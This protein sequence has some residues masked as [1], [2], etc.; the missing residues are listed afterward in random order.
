MKPELYLKTLSDQWPVVSTLWA[1][2]QSR[3]FSQGDLY[4]VARDVSGAQQ[5]AASTIVAKL[6]DCA[7][8]VENK[9]GGQGYSFASHLC[10]FIEYLLE[11]QKLGLLAEITAN[12]DTLRGHL[13]DVRAAL[14]EGRR[15]GFFQKCQEM[16]SRFHTLQRLVDQNTKA[17]YNLVDEAKQADRNLPIKDRYAKVIGAWDSYVRPALEMKS[18]GQPFTTMITQI[19]REFQSWLEDATLSVL[20]ADDARHQLESV[21]FRML[22]FRELLDRSIDIMSRKL[23]PL[24]QQARINTLI[25][26]GASI[27]FRSLAKT[28][29]LEGDN[30]LRLPARVRRVRRAD[31]D[32]L[33]EFYSAFM[34]TVVKEETEA[35]PQGL[36]VEAATRK[37]RRETVADM[38]HWIKTARPVQDICLALRGQYPDATAQSV[39]KVLGALSRD[40]TTRNYVARHDD[41][42]SY[43]FEKVTIIMMRRSFDLALKPRISPYTDVIDV[44]PIRKTKAAMNHG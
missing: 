17:I 27:A 41:Q 40:P 10:P 33:M 34:G 3:T 36:K 30:D 35:L 26:Q 2:H 28:G 13:D 37:A 12:T 5:V 31:S 23:T 22:D 42:K 44:L 11:E 9:R 24:I 8:L 18:P 32:V 16:E 21:H 29:D 38:I 1:N 4:R 7:I 14:I 6:I 15:T 43:P 39:C 19:T 20:M 25:S